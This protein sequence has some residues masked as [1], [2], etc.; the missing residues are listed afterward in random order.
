MRVLLTTISKLLGAWIK[1]EGLILSSLVYYQGRVEE[2][3]AES[4]RSGFVN[5]DR[6]SIRD[7]TLNRCKLDYTQSREVIESPPG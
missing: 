4:S 5:A 3:L 7:N 1:H 6:L 2:R